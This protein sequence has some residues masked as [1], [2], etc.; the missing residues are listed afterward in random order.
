[1]LQTEAMGDDHRPAAA[2]IA[3]LV[4]GIDNFCIAERVPI[5]LVRSREVTEAGIDDLRVK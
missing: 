4:C 2:P 5:I 3:E 1:M